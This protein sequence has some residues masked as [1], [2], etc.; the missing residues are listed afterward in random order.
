M[1]HEESALG[2]V[3][4]SSSRLPEV[5]PYSDATLPK[6]PG[7]AA[8]LVL[9]PVKGYAKACLGM[10]P[11]GPSSIAGYIHEYIAA[12]ASKGTRKGITGHLRLRRE[13]KMTAVLK[14]FDYQAARLKVRRELGAVRGAAS[15]S[16]SRRDR[17]KKRGPKWLLPPGS[18]Q[19]PLVGPPRAFRNNKGEWT[20][21]TRLSPPPPPWRLPPITCTPDVFL[22]EQGPVL[23][24]GRSLM[25][26]RRRAARRRLPASPP[27]RALPDS[28][29]EEEEEQLDTPTDEEPSSRKRRLSNPRSSGKRGAAA[30]GSPDPPRRSKPGVEVTWRRADDYE[31][32]PCCE[33]LRNPPPEQPCSPSHRPNTRERSLRD[34]VWHQLDHFEATHTVAADTEA[35]VDGGARAICKIKGSRA[36]Q[37]IGLQRTALPVL[38]RDVTPQQLQQLFASAVGG[39]D[40]FLTLETWQ[41]L[42]ARLMHPEPPLPDDVVARTFRVIDAS[43][44]GR[45]DFIEF[46]STAFFLTAP[47]S[48]QR[49]LRQVYWFL[50]AYGNGRLTKAVLTPEEL[51]AAIRRG[52][53]QQEQQLRGRG[54]TRTE[55]GGWHN[56]G[57]ALQRAAADLGPDDAL[58]LSEFTALVFLEPELYS[59]VQML[60]F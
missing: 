55:L 59:G 45:V 40:G 53:G 32:E 34:W 5:T 51:D 17:G 36:Q 57:K 47:R 28:S 31:P 10:N 8:A 52:Q 4:Q 26:N 48:A 27:R 25:Q 14:A 3:P 54:T 58:S 35:A 42:L 50:E 1:A 56:W 11:G 33:A 43:S 39:L 12:R 7:G 29:D 30:R 2:D 21:S 6:S 37:L 22:A 24:L 20:L 9:P 46:M 60:T 23:G 44:D 13:K 41:H 38:F 18:P 19:A 49:S 15:A 16:R